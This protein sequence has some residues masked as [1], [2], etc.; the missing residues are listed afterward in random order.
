MSKPFQ[1]AKYKKIIDNCALQ[2]DLD[3][4][5]GGDQAEIGERGINLSGGQKARVGFARAV[6]QDKDIYLLDDPLSAVDA[7]VGHHIFEKCILGSLKSKTVLLVTNALQYI[8]F[9]DRIIV[10][11]GGKLLRTVH[12]MHLSKGTVDIIK[13]AELQRP[14]A[15]TSKEESDKTGLTDGYL[16]FK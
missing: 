3:A 15:L 14:T 6:Y 1:N 4:I 12:T 11:E 2:P 9:C 16:K 13:S 10:L 8:R 7:H 5:Q